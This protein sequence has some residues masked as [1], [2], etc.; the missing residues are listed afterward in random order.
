[1]ESRLWLSAIH[2]EARQDGCTWCLSPEDRPFKIPSV[3]SLHCPDFEAVKND[4]RQFNKLSCNGLAYFPTSVVAPFLGKRWIK[5]FKRKK[6]KLQTSRHL[7]PMT[8]WCRIKCG[9]CQLDKTQV[10]RTASATF[11]VTQSERCT[12]RSFPEC[13]PSQ[14]GLLWSVAAFLPVYSGIVDASTSIVTHVH[15]HTCGLIYNHHCCQSHTG[16]NQNLQATTA[17]DCIQH[18]SW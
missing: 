8:N 14:R 16:F 13:R 1:M 4:A 3:C 6:K 17:P 12:R 18:K 5:V 10:S 15:T 2:T 11:R 9:G 7:R